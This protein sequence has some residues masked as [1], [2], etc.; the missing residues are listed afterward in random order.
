[1]C[2]RSERRRPV[3]LD[4]AILLKRLFSFLLLSHLSSCIGMVK[5][6]MQT[7][8]SPAKGNALQACVARSKNVFQKF[9][10]IY[11]LV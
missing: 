2:E 1:V 8:F 11:S 7:D 9:T 3:Q 6:V 10:L 5:H 4:R